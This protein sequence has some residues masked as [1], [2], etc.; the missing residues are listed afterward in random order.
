MLDVMTDKLLELISAG[1]SEVIEFK[2]SFGDTALETIGAFSNTRGGTL[3][4]GIKD[5][6]DI[7][8]IQVG[9]KT[10]EDMA[11]R[12]QEA[13]DPRLQ[14]FLSI[15]EHGQKSVIII[16]IAAG[17]GAP[18]SVRGRYFR[19]SGKTN[20]RMSH[21]EIMQRMVA[22]TGLSWD[23]F[24]EPGTTLEDLDPER[25]DRFVRA[26]KKIGRRPIPESTL[27]H[28]FLRKMELIRDEIPTRAA[29]LLF[30]KNPESYF[31]AAFLKMGRFRSPT[32]IVDD[33][34]AH[35]TLLDQLD[36]A[37]TWFRERL[38][39]AFVISGKPQRDVV[40]EY[41]L[42]AIRE[43]VTNVLCHRD[44]TGHAHSQIRLYDDRLEIWNSGGLPP[45][46]T[47]DLLLREHDSIPRNR[48]I[49]EAFFYAG[50]IER[51]G[52]GTTRM[53]AEL[54]AVGM[55]PPEFNSDPGRFRLT[56]Y[57]ERFTEERL[58]SMGL[59]ER[60][61]LAVAHVKAHE[62]ISNTDYQTI[63][64]VSKRTASREL[65]ELKLKAI[66]IAEGVGGRGTIYKLKKS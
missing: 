35:G 60:Q 25:V 18:I 10:L 52:S 49:A 54:E 38:E 64:G 12:I 37:T 24:I 32:L 30:G 14:P 63:A 11:N 47:P 50:L 55:P 5:S 46:L 65:N 22:N 7:K 45:S 6:G 39:T 40:W 17:T 66:L 23:A 58:K 61:L 19:R 48:K 8:G 31:P 3:L 59:S 20:Q 33:R 15:I 57:R 41:P 36:E 2:E 53:A 62:I 29:L 21:E 4:L 43:A 44:Y 34:E 28:D 27:D 56:F 16:R 26:V 42:S 13:T 9:K 51:W 1:E